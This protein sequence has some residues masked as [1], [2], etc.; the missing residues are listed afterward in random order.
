M[1]LKSNL[2]F[3]KKSL[4]YIKLEEEKLILF[5]KLNSITLKIY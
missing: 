2:I 5:F 1:N 3:L 4:K